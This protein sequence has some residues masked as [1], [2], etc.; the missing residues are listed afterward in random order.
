MIADGARQAGRDP[1]AIRLSINHS[2]VRVTETEADGEAFLAKVA[3]RQGMDMDAPLVAR[4]PRRD[5]GASR[6]CAGGATKS[7]RSLPHPAHAGF[8]PPDV[9]SLFPLVA[10]LTGR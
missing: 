6:R 8:S 4:R 3:S 1:S 5:D 7:V 9:D 10:A 2:L